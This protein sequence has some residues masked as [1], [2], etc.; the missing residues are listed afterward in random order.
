M[1]PTLS[2][3][4]IERADL[5]M[6]CSLGKKWRLRKRGD[7]NVGHRGSTPAE[8]ASGS[9]ADPIY[10]ALHSSNPSEVIGGA[11]QNWA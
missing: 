8:L 6:S 10:A 4:V 1:M 11:V 2:L 3:L 7:F 9:H 5:G